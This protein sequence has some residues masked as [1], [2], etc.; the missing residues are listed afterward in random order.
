[1][2]EL[3]IYITFCDTNVFVKVRVPELHVNLTAWS[4]VILEKLIIRSGSEESIC[5]LLNTKFHYRVHKSRLLAT[6]LNHK[7][8]I[9]TLK[10]YFTRYIL[11]LFSHLNVALSRMS[12]EIK[13]TTPA[14]QNIQRLRLSVLVSA[15][16]SDR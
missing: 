1:M 7:N 6:I 16:S 9:H 5:L 4:A 15:R 8:P 11:I 10:P 12:W 14:L 13:F 3:T 2:V